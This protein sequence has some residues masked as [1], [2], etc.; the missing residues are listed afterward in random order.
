M[1]LFELWKSP[2]QPLLVMLLHCLALS[3]LELLAFSNAAGSCFFS[4]FDFAIQEGHQQTTLAAEDPIHCAR[5]GCGCPSESQF[6]VVSFHSSSGRC[7]A[8]TSPSLFVAAIGEHLPWI[9][10]SGSWINDSLPWLT[11]H[12]DWESY[13]TGSTVL[14]PKALW[15]LDSVYR[16]RNLGS[17]GPKFNLTVENVVWTDAGPLGRIPG[18]FA[19][20]GSTTKIYVAAHHG[21][22][23]LLDLSKPFTITMWVKTDDRVQVMPIIESYGKSNARNFL[24]WFWSS[25]YQDQLFISEPRTAYT[26]INK[27]DRLNWRHLTCK[28]R[29]ASKFSFYLNG[30]EWPLVHEENPTPIKEMEIIYIGLRLKTNQRFYGNMACLMIFDKALTADEIKRVSSLCG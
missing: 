24:F 23:K 22:K 27:S 4:K 6:C 30:N 21:G 15:P 26:T 20:L 9:N 5:Q 16:G 10:N 17:L 3:L 7:W 25:R 18:N 8:R 2:S 29:G 1:Q 14:Q 12:G 11:Q 19:R 28:H 13:I